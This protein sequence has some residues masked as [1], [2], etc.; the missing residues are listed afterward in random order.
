MELGIDFVV[1]LHL[2]C[3]TADFRRGDRLGPGD[4][5][6]EWNRPPQP[7]WMDDATYARMRA[8][9]KVREVEVRVPQRGF[10]D[11]KFV[12]VTSLLNSEVYAASEIAKL[13]RQRWLAEL[14]IRAV[15]STM[16]FDLLRG[17]TPE[18]L[19]KEPAEPQQ[20]F[21]L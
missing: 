8:S 21:G 9:I 12:V 16:G 14:D 10:R 7:E 17:Q 13:Y 18:M 11:S 5:I 3:R 2:R 4:H 15:K 19:R 1:R 6:V 20:L